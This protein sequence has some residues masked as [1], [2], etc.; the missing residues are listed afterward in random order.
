MMIVFYKRWKDEAKKTGWEVNVKE[1]NQVA[2]SGLSL[3]IIQEILISK[4]LYYYEFEKI[5]GTSPNIC[6]PYITELRY[7]IVL[8][9]MGQQKILMHKNMSYFYNLLKTKSAI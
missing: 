6:P 8:Y 4:C 2:N 1:Y 5:I 9:E 3:M 7:Q